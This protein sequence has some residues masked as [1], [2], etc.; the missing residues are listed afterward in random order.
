[1][2]DIVEFEQNNPEAVVLGDEKASTKISFQLAQDFYNEITGRSENI[3]EYSS[4]PFILNLGHIEQLYHRIEQST[5]QYN[6]CSFNEQ[7]TVSYVDD[8]SER[9]SSLARE[10]LNKSATF[11]KIS[12]TSFSEPDHESTDIF[13]R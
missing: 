10:T 11:S 7:Y 4:S 3:K 12:E 6:I 2:N 5:E 8:S 13:R 9:Y 1:M